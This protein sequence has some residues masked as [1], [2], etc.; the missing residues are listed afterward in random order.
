[1]YTIYIYIYIYI[2]GGMARITQKGCVVLF[3]LWSLKKNILFLFL[4]G[5][6]RADVNQ[7]KQKIQSLNLISH[8]S[9][10]KTVTIIISLIANIKIEIV[11]TAITKNDYLNNNSTNN[12]NNNNNNNN[13]STNNINI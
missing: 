5:R 9:I 13:K 10:M 8:I 11:I 6:G 12:N 1:M 7:Q 3:P 2:R 4:G